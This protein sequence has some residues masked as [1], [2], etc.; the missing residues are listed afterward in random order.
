MAS[1]GGV[2]FSN[3]EMFTAI[4][5]LRFWPGWSCSWGQGAFLYQFT[6]FFQNVQNMSVVVAG[7]AFTPYLIGLMIGSFLVARLAL[8]FGARRII[9]GGFGVMG[10]S[11]VLLSFVRVDTSYW[12]LL[13]PITLIG[14][15]VGLALPARTQVVLAAPPPE[16]VGS[17]AAINTASGQSGYAL[18]VILSS[19]LVTQLADLAFLKPLAQAGVPEA[20]LS[21]DQ[22]SPSQHFCPDRIRGISKRAASRVGP[23]LGKL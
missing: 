8:R 6:A 14:F 20:V 13:A 15:G 17:A 7:L 10:A 12:S 19:L 21:Q 11:L 16:L 23:C 22:G 5:G 3:V 1:S 2:R 9:A 4:P 18:G